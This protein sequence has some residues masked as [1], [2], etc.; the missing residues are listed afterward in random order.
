MPMDES[1][2]NTV[3]YNAS[4]YLVKINNDYI[5]IYTRVNQ[6][7]SHRPYLLH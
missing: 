3:S 1:F 5:Y 2:Q 6:A 7:F 4:K